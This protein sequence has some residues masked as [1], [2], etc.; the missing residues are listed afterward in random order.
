MPSTPAINSFTVSSTNIAINVTAGL[1]TTHVQWDRSWVDNGGASNDLEAV[2]STG[3][4]YTQNFTPPSSPGDYTVLVRARIGSTAS[5]WVSRGFTIADDEP[6]PVEDPN[7]SISN[8]NLSGTGTISASW[9]VGNAAYMR[10]SNSMAIY[11][12][13]AN[14]ATQ[15]FM[16]FASYSERSFSS[17]LAGDGSALVPGATYYIWVYAYD[18]DGNRLGEY[19]FTQFSKTKP[20]AFH[21]NVAKTSNGSFNLTYDEWERLLDKVNEFKAYRGDAQIAF[22]KS[23]GSG[24]MS[25]I[26][27]PS[28][29]SFN[30]ARNAIANMP[31]TIAP[32][33]NVNS[34]TPITGALLN[35]LRNS[36]NSIT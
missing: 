29:N 4:S 7:P 14:D 1:D 35:A 27:R 6:P 20:L 21:W 25:G 5:S 30:I 15:Y 28:A 31:Y 16:G 33:P 22:N 23:L 12:S 11:M 13:G 32:P 18:V 10:S 24:A 17:G 19:N 9:T 34:T 8:L 3:D 26:V 36:L 2:L